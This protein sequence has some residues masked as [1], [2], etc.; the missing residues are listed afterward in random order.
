[1]NTFFK[2]IFGVALLATLALSQTIKVGTNASYPPFEFIDEQNKISGFDMDL[3]DEISKIVGF[4]YEIVNLAFDALI[5][6]LKAGKIDII[7]SAMSATPVRQKAVD[8]SKPYYNTMN[9]FIKRADNSDL[10][11]F[12]QL[13]GKKIAV[14]LGTVQELAAKEIKSAKVMA[15]DDIYGAVMAVKN[16]KADALIVDS[17][18]GYGYL[19]NNKD[20]VEFLTL[21]DGSDGFSFAYDKGKYKEF[22][23]KIDKA[24]DELKSNGIYD[25]L[26]IKYDLK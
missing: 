4:K 19:K 2:L 16:A 12:E 25:K 10:T 24:I 17:S 5:P 6:A 23:A 14:Q 11:K 3:I 21:P 26:L 15:I 18:I 8:F 22:Q 1:M 9:L 20:L 7:A 13:E